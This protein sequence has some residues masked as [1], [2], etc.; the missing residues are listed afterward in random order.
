MRFL[1]FAFALSASFS[2]ASLVAC[3]GATIDPSPG[4]GAPA[5]TAPAPSGTISPGRVQ[6]TPEIPEVD[7]TTCTE[8]VAAGKA[9]PVELVADQA[10]PAF[11]GVIAE[12]DYHLV[13]VQVHMGAGG[14]TAPSSSTIASTLRVR[15]GRFDLSHDVVD[16]SGKDQRGRFIALYDVSGAKL[17]LKALCAAGDGADSIDAMGDIGFSS[18]GQGDLT[19]VVP[20]KGSS[21]PVVATYLYMR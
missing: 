7:T 10:A 16:G 18:H 6:P 19:L 9:V 8:P 1:S 15:N 11:G 12:G 20:S 5:A 17:S 3:G 14:V 21:I 13:E 4:E 2:F